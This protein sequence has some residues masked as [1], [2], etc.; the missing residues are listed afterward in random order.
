MQ[1][2]LPWSISVM[3]VLSYSLSIFEN[4]D[5]LVRWDYQARAKLVW[6]IIWRI[7]W[8]FHQKRFR[9]SRTFFAIFVLRFG[10]S[11]CSVRRVALI[12]VKQT[13]QFIFRLAFPAPLPNHKQQFI[14]YICFDAVRPFVFSRSCL[15]YDLMIW[16]NSCGASTHA[17]IF[18]GVR[19][20]YWLE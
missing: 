14:N 6:S 5:L 8:L 15:A 13:I 4:N 2:A 7:S 12:F 1:C 11:F 10:I 3:I 19:I 17:L 9:T 20:V 18:V 16:K